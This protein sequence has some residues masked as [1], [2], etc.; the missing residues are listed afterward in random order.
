[1]LYITGHSSLTLFILVILSLFFRACL[2]TG[3]RAVMERW[4]GRVALVTG[5]SV[6][7]GA[8]IAVELARLGMKVVGCAR[9]VGKIQKLAAECQSAGHSGVLVPFKCDLTNEEEILSM[10]AAIKEQHRG[11]DVCINNAGLAHPEPLLSGKT[12]GWKN[13]MDV[14]VFGLSICAR[15]AYQSM[16]E[17]H[18]DDGHIININSECGHHVIPLA[19]VHFYTATKFA[20]TALTEG[21][22]Q[23]LRAENT[24]IRATSISPSLVKT[25]F[26]LRLY[27]NNPDIKARAFSAYKPLEAK[28][29]VNAV[30]YV[31]GAP[32]HVLVCDLLLFSFSFNCDLFNF[33]CF[34]VLCG[35]IKR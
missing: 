29:V 4:R 2:N 21:L 30:I 22:R 8:A 34:L 33:F 3:V 17:R 31:L 15:E 18:V 6:G 28:D 26:P 5:A 23:E 14:N 20:V 27:S 1:M 35:V 13:M 16:K 19:D 7:I 24:H 32:P 9:D 11:V 12:S 25:E 10:F